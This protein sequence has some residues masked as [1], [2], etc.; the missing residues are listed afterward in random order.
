MAERYPRGVRRMVAHLSELLRHTLEGA[1][2]HEVSLEQEL[3][4]LRRYVEIMKMRL[5]GRLEF[6]TDVEDGLLEAMVPNLV[7]QPI[8]ENAFKHGV[9]ALPEGGLIRLTARREDD[10]LVL[11]VWN[12]GQ[13]PEPG[14]EREARGMGLR[15]TRARLAQLYGDAH[16]FTLSA[17][18]GSGVRAEIRLPYHTGGDLKAAGASPEDSE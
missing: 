17:D 18:G 8:V 14:A 16:R 9:S 2:E 12:S 15:N 5:Q 4:F 6:E 10:W 1:G 11:T 13:A 3:S 7:L